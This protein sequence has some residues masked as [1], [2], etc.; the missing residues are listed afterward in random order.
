MSESKRREAAER[1]QRILGRAADHLAKAF[2]DEGRLIEAG[3]RAALVVLDW[4]T[5]PE[6]ELRALRM[7]YFSGAQH[8]WGSVIG[9]MDEDREPTN[10]DLRRM[11]LIANELDG[12]AREMMAL[13]NETGGHA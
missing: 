10:A 6:A 2:V 7:A 12:F 9:I 3:W 1:K 8:L 5:K 4:E 11:S 13:L